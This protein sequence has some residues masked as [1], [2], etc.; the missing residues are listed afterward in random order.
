MCK[1]TKKWHFFD[2]GLKS[3]FHKPI[4]DKT[5][6]GEVSMSEE[7]N[8]NEG[9]F[10]DSELQ[11]IMAEIESLEQ[12]SLEDDAAQEEVVAEEAPVELSE[13]ELPADEPVA[14]HVAEHVE[15][16]PVQEDNVAYMAE[17]SSF[18]PSAHGSE[19]EFHGKG[20]MNFEMNFPIGE[21]HAELKVMNGEVVLSFGDISFSLS[22]SECH[23]K[24][25][26]GASFSIPV[27]QNSVAKK[28]A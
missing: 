15:P 11:D 5:L 9:N 25:P 10:N 14:E 3:Q 1:V 26:G 2:V 20:Q 24:M 6:K 8:N 22:E 27:S 18:K 19:V 21:G 13:D 23:A 16:E 4:S 7:N 28:A 17:G 12:E